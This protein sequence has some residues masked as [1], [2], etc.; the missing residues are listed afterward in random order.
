MALEKILVVIAIAF[1]VF[2]IWGY[3]EKFVRILFYIGIVALLIIA[4][5]SFFIYKD[6]MDLKESF[7]LSTKKVILVDGDKAIAGFLLN[8]KDNAIEEYD[9]EKI[10]YYLSQKDYN[11]ILGSSYKLFIF[12]I[13][14]ISD[15]DE[16]I[17]AGQEKIK[18]DYVI[19]A[20]KS[21]N[22]ETSLQQK[23]DLFEDILT[24]NILDSKATFI[25]SELKKGN[26]RVYPETALF[27][28]V[29][30]VPMPFVKDMSKKV[31]SSLSD[32]IKSGKI[33]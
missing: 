22:F 20:L 5:I 11:K 18:R 23:T 19:S 21:S 31:F 8:G 7:A 33:A 32:K 9:L 14:I 15:L 4:A 3:L 24:G 28:A 2:I 27:K 25:F 1:V 13:S 30:F 29:K 26:I 12:D 17:I 6:V 16:E 10:S